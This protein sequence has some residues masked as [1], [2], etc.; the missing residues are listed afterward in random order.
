MERGES[1][2]KEG[3]PPPQKIIDPHSLQ[4]LERIDLC[5]DINLESGL[6]LRLAFVSF[7]SYV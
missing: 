5:Y 4:L 7:L 3:R 2:W 6:G 1:K